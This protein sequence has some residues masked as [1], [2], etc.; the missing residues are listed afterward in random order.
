MRRL[1]IASLLAGLTGHT[2]SHR[3][4]NDGPLKRRKTLGFGPHHPHAVF[5]SSPYQIQTNGF[6]PQSPTTHPF[7]V[8]DLFA[9]DILADQLSDSIS[10]KIRKDSYADPNTGVSHVY[11]R[12]VVNGI[13]VADGDMNINIKDGMVISYGSSVSLN[14]SAVQSINRSSSFTKARF[15]R[16]SRTTT[17]SY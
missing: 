13:E 15:L 7:D 2:L 5:Y 1:L 10:Y 4:R 17:A 12:Q 14:P 6:L 11:I 16:L 9:K 8:A 3:T